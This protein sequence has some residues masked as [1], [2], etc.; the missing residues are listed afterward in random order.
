MPA[1]RLLWLAS[2]S[3]GSRACGAPTGPALATLPLNAPPTTGS[4]EVRVWPLP[5]TWPLP[6]SLWLIAR[7]TRMLRWTI[8]TFSVWP[9]IP[10]DATASR[11]SRRASAAWM[12]DRTSSL[13]ATRQLDSLVCGVVVGHAPRRTTTNASLTITSSMV[14]AMP[15]RHSMPRGCGR[16]QPA[17]AVAWSR[18]L[19]LA[20]SLTAPTCRCNVAMGRWP[21]G[22][23][24]V[25][26]VASAK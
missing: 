4:C 5:Q 17:R 20:P 22:L 6:T 26:P 25:E 15:S 16:W 21:C 12:V 7:R 24:P 9:N 1:T 14:Q 23:T 13:P 18:M 8:P 19:F 10:A 2:R 3:R 11:M